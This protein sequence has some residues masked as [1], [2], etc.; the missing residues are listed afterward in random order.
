M[1]T[2]RPVLAGST[3]SM[4]SAPVRPTRLA[5]RP[6]TKT[7]P[8]VDIKADALPTGRIAET[9]A[10]KPRQPLET[11]TPAK[12]LAKATP[13]PVATVESIS[14]SES[15]PTT[16]P[17]AV[18][19]DTHKRVSWS[20]DEMPVEFSSCN[21]PN[22]VSLALIGKTPTAPVDTI[23]RNPVN[24]KTTIPV[25]K[26]S[27][28]FANDKI[29]NSD[30]QMFRCPSDSRLASLPVEPSELPASETAYL[31]VDGTFKNFD[32]AFN[33]PAPEMAALATPR[34][35]R[36]SS[37]K[38]LNQPKITTE[39][40]VTSDA[41]SD[42]AHNNMEADSQPQEFGIA[43]RLSQ[44]PRPLASRKEGAQSVVDSQRLKV[45]EDEEEKS[46]DIW[47]QLALERG[48]PPPSPT[49]GTNVLSELPVNTD[50]TKRRNSYSA[51]M[52]TDQNLGIYQARQVI[53][54][55]IPRIQDGT[56]S[57]E[58]F[59]LL[60]EM[61]Q[62]DNLW[63]TGEEGQPVFD[64]LVQSLSF[65]ILGDSPYA[66]MDSGKLRLLRLQAIYT[67]NQLQ[68]NNKA[69]LGRWSQHIL[70]SVAMSYQDYPDTNT[71]APRV[72]HAMT[73]LADDM[74]DL[75]DQDRNLDTLFK[76]L[77]TNRPL[78]QNVLALNLLT[79]ALDQGDGTV[80]KMT[81]ARLGRIACHC[82]P[83]SDTD[84]RMAAFSLAAKMWAYIK[85]ES[86]FWKLLCELSEEQKNLVVYFA[87]KPKR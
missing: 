24:G 51:K 11:R 17:A 58:S 61:I 7:M 45:Y 37:L 19:P 28:S 40:R 33:I 52:T 34:V 43:S 76:L 39:H 67:I 62:K 29:N 73:R 38:T 42:T 71:P 5:R 49:L 70:R 46:E 23:T 74:V 72:M 4:S 22:E 48:T 64:D 80:D 31:S 15:P 75:A 30:R 12:S 66:D 8:K 50:I 68:H 35:P 54:R 41:T 82:I 81:E 6:D 44:S 9:P 16:E 63:A 60:R 18:A 56:L 83:D 14:D 36:R 25:G 3:G 87:A 78:S 65:V 10:T 32:G 57:P 21:P 26:V 53:G 79:R 20:E 85:P 1:T 69:D 77:E 59:K 86:R 84:V 13:T 55:A 2:R 47:L 27:A